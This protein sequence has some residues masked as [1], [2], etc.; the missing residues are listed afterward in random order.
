LIR[1][2]SVRD[3]ISKITVE[4]TI[5]TSGLRMN[6]HTSTH[7]WTLMLTAL[8]KYFVSVN[9]LIFKGLDDVIMFSKKH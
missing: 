8:H 2:A 9:Y 3:P 6:A 4:E 1:Q 5:S 7:A